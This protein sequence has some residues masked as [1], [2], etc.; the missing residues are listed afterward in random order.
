MWPSDKEYENELV[1]V[2]GQRIYR[3]RV[4]YGEMEGSYK[5]IDRFCIT[6]V[7]MEE[8]TSMVIP[9]YFTRKS[10]KLFSK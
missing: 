4:N 7:K 2:W 8:L 3:S 10:T 9:F 5:Y 6:A 1:V